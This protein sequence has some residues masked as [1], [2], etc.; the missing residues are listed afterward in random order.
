VITRP[1]DLASRL[2]PEP[3]NFDAWFY[4]NVGLLAVF[5]LA[6]G[7]RFVLAPG[8]AVVLPEIAGARA[9]ATLTSDSITVLPSGQIY[10][11]NGQI[12]VAQLGVWL[13]AEARK[14]RH[15]S[16]LVKASS[17]VTIAQLGEITSVAQA[18]GFHVVEA[19]E[20]PAAA[21]GR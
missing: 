4:V 13:Q 16:L 6:F 18:A 17:A 5:F 10:G 8:L 14:T 11:D 15:P 1:L 19:A 9:G 20:E 3:R 2:R 12:T 21:A 7:S